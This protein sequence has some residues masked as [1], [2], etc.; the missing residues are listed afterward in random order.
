MPSA[1]PTLAASSPAVRLRCMIQGSSEMVCHVSVATVRPS[2][3]SVT[4]DRAEHCQ[5][6]DKCPLLCA[7]AAVVEEESSTAGWSLLS[8]L[9]GCRHTASVLSLTFHTSFLGIQT[10]CSG[11]PPSGCSMYSPSSFPHKNQPPQTQTYSK[12]SLKVLRPQPTLKP[13]SHI[14]EA[15]IRLNILQLGRPTG[16]DR[17][18]SKGT[19]TGSELPHIRAIHF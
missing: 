14:Q 7:P 17:A 5:I 12:C 1:L 15:T 10:R 9:L 4:C 16:Q 19:C 6:L 18:S 11:F 2:F 8:K 13:F 3:H